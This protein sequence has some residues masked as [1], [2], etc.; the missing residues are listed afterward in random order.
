M[1]GLLH[2]YIGYGKGKSTA[3][4]GLLLRSAGHGNRVLYGQFLKSGRSGELT[5]LP[6]LGGSVKI[7]QPAVYLQKFFRNLSPEEQEE[8]TRAQRA[9]VEEMAAEMEGGGYD[10]VIMDEVLDL[11]DLGIVTEAELISLADRRPEGTELVFTG[12]NA[13]PDIVA[14]ADYVTEFN[15][16]KHPY[17]EG[18][19]ARRGVEF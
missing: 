3:A 9:T 13:G 18:V 11:A 19:P 6:K 4:L 12:H 7:W 1:A 10:L 5:A 8:M 16:R 14:L 15:A 17:N 2:V